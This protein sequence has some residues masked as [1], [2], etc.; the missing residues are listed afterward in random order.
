MVKK[1]NFIF[2]SFSSFHLLI[3]TLAP[4]LVRYTLPLDAMEGTTWGHQF[5]WGY[6]KNPFMNGWLTALAVW[7]G[8]NSGWVTYLFSQISVVICF[9]AV[10]TLGKKILSPLFALIGVLLLEGV[11]YYNFHAIDFNDNTLELGA[12]A[13]CILSFY[14]AIHKKNYFYWMLTGFFAGL[15]LMIKY[16]VIVLFVPML[17]YLFV[18]PNARKN[19]FSL[20]FYCGLVI[21]LLVISPH[22]AWLFS[23]HFITVNYAFDRVSSSQ[24]WWVHF[25]FPLQ[26]SWQMFITFFPAGL[27]FLILLFLKTEQTHDLN[28]QALISSDKLFLIIIGL[29]PFLL[30]I[31]ISALSGIKL[32]AGWGQPLM[33]LWGLLLLAWIKPIIQLKQ[34]YR[35]IIVLMLTIIIAVSGY[36]IALIRADKPSSANYP[37]KLIAS[38]ITETWHEKFGT[39]IPYV[40]GNR[41]LAG[42]ISL[43]SSDHPAV[44]I[45]W[46]KNIS[47]WIDEKK[48]KK[49]GAIFVWD[50][51]ENNNISFQTIKK[52][53]PKMTEPQLMLFSW[54][55]NFAMPP[56][57]IQVAYLRPEKNGRIC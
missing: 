48:L 47:T 34:L 46:N 8:G 6:D 30:T 23:H 24:Q 39:P 18:E 54:R 17:F 37:G 1:L 12:W 3:W 57:K 53:F 32:R 56:V 25:F 21:F 41:W 16:Y 33:S 2:Y 7:L 36:S 20:P 42:N 44:Y 43:Y 52:R 22:I 45:D 40:A 31:F 11:Q 5:E 10:W 13:L 35:F 27:L 19:L 28:T 29:G 4:V 9:W 49:F 15:C 55:R 38:T 50:L 26:F 14:Q 51:S